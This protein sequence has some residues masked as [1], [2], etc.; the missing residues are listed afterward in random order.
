MNHLLMTIVVSISKVRKSL[1]KVKKKGV[2]KRSLHINEVMTAMKKIH[3]LDGVSVNINR[4]SDW[5]KMK[6]CGIKKRQLET[7]HPE[8]ERVVGKLNQ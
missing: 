1:S 4:G 8:Q 6:K 2:K 3:R 7:N 5:C